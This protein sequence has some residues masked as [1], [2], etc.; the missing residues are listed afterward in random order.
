MRAS[1]GGSVPRPTRA[2]PPLPRCAHAARDATQG[3]LALGSALR[4]QEAGYP[5]PMARWLA[6]A[7]LLVLGAA[8]ARAATARTLALAEVRAPTGGLVVRAGVGPVH[9]PGARPARDARGLVA[10]R[11]S[12]RHERRGADARVAAR[13]AASARAAS[14]SPRAGSPVRA[15][16]GLWST[17]CRSPCARTGR[18]A[19]GKE[20]R[21]RAAAGRRRRHGRLA[22]RHRR[23]ARASRVEASPGS[24]RAASCGS[25]SRRR[26]ARRPPGPCARPTRFPGG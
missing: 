21:G 2:P 18:P 15:C 19:R 22:R 8:P 25:G 11:A 4:S 1:T 3:G 16:E 5:C 14:S 24:R 7:L 12:R 13:R 10:A 9:L 20:L 23:P 17:A 6:L 26:P